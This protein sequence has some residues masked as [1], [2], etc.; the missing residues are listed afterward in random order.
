MRDGEGS[1]TSVRGHT[2]TPPHTGKDQGC[3]SLLQPVAVRTSGKDQASKR[4]FSPSCQEASA[5]RGWA[6][7]TG[8]CLQGTS[9]LSQSSFDGGHQLQKLALRVHIAIASLLGVNQLSCYEH[10]KEASDLGSPL[11]ADVQT[12]R[13]LIF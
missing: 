1:R 13:E 9:G 10:F 5:G 4:H 12:A 11:A 2:R 3:P 6:T 8:F 7:V